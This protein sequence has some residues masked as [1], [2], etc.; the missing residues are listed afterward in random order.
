[1]KRRWRPP[2]TQTV[3]LTVPIPTAPRCNLRHRLQLITG[4]NRKD[5]EMPDVGPQSSSTPGGSS[6]ARVTAAKDS[7]LTWCDSDSNI[8]AL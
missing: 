3:T 5:G 2:V 7:D 4:A 6:N 8:R 1:M